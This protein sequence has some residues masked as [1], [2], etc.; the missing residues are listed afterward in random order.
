MVSEFP[1]TGNSRFV[2]DVIR[3][4]LY[5]FME[6][7]TQMDAVS[8][9]LINLLLNRDEITLIHSQ[10]VAQIADRIL[11][12]IFDRKPELRVGLP[13]CQS[14]VD[15]LENRKQIEAFVSQASRIFDIGKLKDADIV[16]KRPRQL[17]DTELERIYANPR[18]GAE[19]ADKI[20]LL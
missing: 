3:R 6:T 8:E 19:I 1:R 10:M 16:N 7:L 4:K 9:V 15:V 18:A 11:G 14:T 2:N 13:G 17:T 5:A 12:C 20:P